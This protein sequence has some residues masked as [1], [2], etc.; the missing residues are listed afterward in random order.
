MFFLDLPGFLTGIGS[1][2][3]DF[4]VPFVV[5]RVFYGWMCDPPSSFVGVFLVSFLWLGS[6]IRLSGVFF[7]RKMYFYVFFALGYD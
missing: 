3:R 6:W 4:Q 2:R 7:R 1:G 5:W